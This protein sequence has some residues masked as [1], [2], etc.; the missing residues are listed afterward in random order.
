[1]KSK[2]FFSFTRYISIP[3]C[4]LI[5]SCGQPGEVVLYPAPEGE[6]ASADFSMKVNGEPVFIYRARV[7][8]IPVNQVW[9]GYQRP[10]EQTEIASFAYFDFSGKVRVEVT[11][12]KTIESVDIRPKSYGIKPEMQGSTISLTLDRPRQIVVEVNGWHQALHIF[13]NAIET[14]V[15]DSTDP[16]VR[17]FGRGVHDAGIMQA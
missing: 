12:N 5:L 11:A 17:Y 6:A 14:N 1:M 16:R 10:K 7:S 13:S 9:P 4:L 15:P 2:R 3:V 8:A